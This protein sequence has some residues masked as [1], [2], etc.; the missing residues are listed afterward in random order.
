[1]IL[2][3]MVSMMR[4]HATAVR[5]AELHQERAAGRRHESHWNMGAKYQRGQQ[6]D[7]QRIRS[8]MVIGASLHAEGVYDAR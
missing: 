6:S 1:M 3:M 7:G 4:R 5:R 2:R 8:P